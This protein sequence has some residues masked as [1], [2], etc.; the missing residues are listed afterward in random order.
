M[1]TAEGAWTQNKH[2]YISQFSPAKSALACKYFPLNKVNYFHIHK[3]QSEFLRR[4]W[5]EIKM[6]KI[7]FKLHFGLLYQLEG[8]G[9]NTVCVRM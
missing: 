7:T 1:S 9:K 3:T 2:T 5:K 4:A 6:L 8:N